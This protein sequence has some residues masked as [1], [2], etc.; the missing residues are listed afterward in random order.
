MTVGAKVYAGIY[1]GQVRVT[2]EVLPQRPDQIDVD[3]WDDIVEV[4]VSADPGELAVHSL[5]YGPGEAPPALPVLTPDGPGTYRIRAHVRGRDRRYDDML[6]EGDEPTEDYL[7]SIWSAPPAAPLIIRATDRCGHGIRIANLQTQ[8]R[9]DA[10][11]P[12]PYTPPSHDYD[13]L[14]QARLEAARRRS[15]PPTTS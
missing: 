9:A 12:P 2:I 10:P 6:D 15:E 1:S 7:F 3:P 11:S 8:R 13:E 5:E 14:T 4:T